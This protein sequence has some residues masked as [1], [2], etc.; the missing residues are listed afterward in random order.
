M[1]DIARDRDFGDETVTDKREKVQPSGVP[2]QWCWR[3]LPAR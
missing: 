1:K 3:M 2:P